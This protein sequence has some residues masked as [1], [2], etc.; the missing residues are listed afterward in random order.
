MLTFNLG[1]AAL[2]Q[3]NLTTFQFVENKLAVNP[4]V[5]SAFFHSWLMGSYYQHTGLSQKAVNQFID[6]MD[7]ARQIPSRKTD[8]PILAFQTL[9]QT[10][11]A[12]DLTASRRAWEILELESKNK[13]NLSPQYRSL[14]LALFEINEGKLSE[15]LLRI[16][17]IFDS[18]QKGRDRLHAAD[19]Y[20]WLLLSLGYYEKGKQVIEAICEYRKKQNFSTSDW[21]HEVLDLYFDLMTLNL[22]QIEFQKK[23]LILI[24]KM[25]LREHERGISMAQFLYYINHDI[26]EEKSQAF[27]AVALIP[28]LQRIGISLLSQNTIRV[29]FLRQLRT[30]LNDEI[31]KLLLD[32]HISRLTEDTYLFAQ[33]FKKLSQFKA[34]AWIQL[35]HN[36]ASP[37]DMDFGQSLQTTELLVDGESRRVMALESQETLDTQPLLVELLLS[38]LKNPHGLSKESASFG[39][40]YTHYDPLQ[41]DP[42]IYNL[43]SRLRDWFRKQDLSIKITTDKSGWV[44]TH[45]ELITFYYREKDNFNKKENSFEVKSP[46]KTTKP[47]TSH[48][49]LNHSPLHPRLDWIL[50]VLN[51]KGLITRAEFMKRFSIQKSTAANDFN[52]LINLKLIQRHGK[53][54]GIYY[55]LTEENR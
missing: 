40:G 11:W 17:T 8:I 15:A 46:L 16:E 5:L 6:S 53:G 22:S 19:Y 12:G 54:R 43:I 7:R 21:E 38:L 50:M 33:T 42:I 35:L 52:S 47:H 18:N 30:T 29:G 4:S 39:I 20:L 13:N 28:L 31:A 1:V 23:L 51:K 14:A 55:T 41:H 48:S 32:L 26:P 3:E 36:S 9:K 45:N 25:K 10:V 37:F 2:N 27:T 44:L 49:P 24:D 34:T